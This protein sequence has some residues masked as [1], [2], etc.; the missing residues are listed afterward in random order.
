MDGRHPAARLS[1]DGRSLKIVEEHADLVRTVFRRYLELGKVRLLAEQ[2]ERNNLRVPARVLSTGKHIGGSPLTRGQIYK[3]L[4]NPAYI[5]EVHHRGQIYQGKHTA[6]IDHAT[7]D[8]VQAKLRDNAQG[9]QRY[10]TAKARCLLAGKL[11]DDAGEPFVASHASKG[12]IRYRYYVSRKLQFDAAAKDGDGLRVPALE[13]EKAV[14]LRLAQSVSDPLR[15]AA[16]LA[17]APKPEELQKAFQAADKLSGKLR[18]R[19]FSAVNSLVERIV[20]GGGSVRISVATEALSE[21]LELPSLTSD[22]VALDL[23]VPFRLSR[24]GSALRIIAADGRVVSSEFG[25]PAL[26]ALLLKA[27]RLWDRLQ[28][29]RLTLRSFPTLKPSATLGSRS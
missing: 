26:I 13:L 17:I 12:K 2:L 29:E 8:A 11:F 18:D 24:R 10:G 27:R 20:I 15:L 1:A 3:L 7:W 25:D 14:A 23:D 16:E 19:D 9:T 6:I 21:A 5:G 28:R 4:S 22:H